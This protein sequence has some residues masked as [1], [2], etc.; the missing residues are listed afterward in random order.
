[1]SRCDGDREI[2]SSG[3]AWTIKGVPIS[4]KDRTK[5][6]EELQSKYLQNN[7][8]LTTQE[9]RGHFF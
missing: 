3:A 5:T 4:N 9:A 8:A 1:M 6:E 2:M 7:T